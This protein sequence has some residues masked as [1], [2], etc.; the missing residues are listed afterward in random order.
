MA[1]VLVVDDVAGVR[2]LCTFVLTARGHEVIQTDNGAEA[3]TLYESERPDAVLLDLM[4]PEMDGLAT[5]EAIRAIDPNARVAMLT[6][7]RDE[8]V[9]RRALAL[10]ARDY[11]VKP[12]HGHR[13]EEAVE[14]LLRG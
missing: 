13:V 4:M 14:R 1:R 10:G 7:T 3:V 11:V 12:F 9:V 5:L 2:E 8:P 6:G